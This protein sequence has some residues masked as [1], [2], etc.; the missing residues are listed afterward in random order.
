MYASTGS[1]TSLIC[2]AARQHVKP[3]VHDKPLKSK[4]YETNLYI[5]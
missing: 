1:I 5:Y 4:R 3:A 2:K